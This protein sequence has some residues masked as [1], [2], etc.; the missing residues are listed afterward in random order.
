M[1]EQ[2]QTKE[3]PFPVNLKSMLIAEVFGTCLFVQTGNAANCVSLYIHHSKKSVLAMT[4]AALAI[5]GQPFVALVWAN[6]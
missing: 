5:G 2:A 6:D 3:G 1:F 4:A